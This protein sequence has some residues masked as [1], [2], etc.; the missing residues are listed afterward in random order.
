MEAIHEN[1]DY[2]STV[3]QI[4]KIESKCLKE[5]TRLIA[6]E[7]S[8]LIF[9]TIFI[10]NGESSDLIIDQLKLTRKQFYSRI[11][12]LLKA[13]LVRRYK[14]KYFLTSYGTVIYDTQK[15]FENAV[16][17]YWK[18]KSIDLIE[19]SNQDNITKEKRI[20]IIDQLITNQ[21]IK[22]ILLARC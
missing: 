12:R 21:Q 20:K 4:K 6:D 18:L 1:I 17:N 22:K 14:G 8:L 16:K 2:V 10:M 7:K 5:F 19:V 11:G 15:L 13:K 9:G 3:D